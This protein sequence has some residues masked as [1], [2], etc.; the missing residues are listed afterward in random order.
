MSGPGSPK[1]RT[2]FR[3][4]P[5]C[6]CEAA[7]PV[8]FRS[9]G[10]RWPD[11]NEEDEKSI[12]RALAGL[13]K[14][15]HADACQA[16]ARLEEEHAHR[17]SWIWARLQRSPLATL[18]GPLARLA[19]SAGTAIGGTAPDDVARTYADHGWLADASA[20]EALAFAPA[21]AE[22]IVA[23]TVRHLLDPWLDASARAFQAS[24]DRQP[25]PSAGDQPT[26]AA[27][28]DECIVFVDGIAL[29]TRL[30]AG[31]TSGGGRVQGHDRA[32]LGGDPDGDRHR[33]TCR[34]P[35]CRRGC[36]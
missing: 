13:P 16:V 29:R 15:P 32:P 14:L 23:A 19:D 2:P 24:V 31:R 36:R 18:L 4:S 5:S 9:I 30:P 26:V 21:E 22:D 33:Q 27:A 28:E 34:H 7:P 1:P 12:R 25:L 8:S 20:R 10:E 6:S 17:R 3:E 11:L 35:R